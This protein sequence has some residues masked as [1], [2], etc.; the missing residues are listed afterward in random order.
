M[1]RSHHELEDE[2]EGHEASLTTLHKMEQNSQ[3][4]TSVDELYPGYQTPT[5]GSRTQ[6]AA[7]KA[8]I[9]Q[10]NSKPL[11]T[12]QPPT[13]QYPADALATKKE[14][15][16]LRGQLYGESIKHLQLKS[17]L[18]Q[19]GWPLAYNKAD[20]PLEIV[21]IKQ[22]TYW[23]NRDKQALFHTFNLLR[24]YVDE[25]QL[26]IHQQQQDIDNLRG[27]TE[28][29][30][31]HID[32]QDQVSD[33]AIASGAI[34]KVPYEN[35]GK[36]VGEERP[37]KVDRRAS[38]FDEQTVEPRRRTLPTAPMLSSRLPTVTRSTSPP[39][40]I[41]TPH[42]PLKSVDKFSGA[43]KSQYEPWQEQILRIF[44]TPLCRNIPVKEQLMLVLNKVT[45]EAALY[46]LPRA[47]LNSPRPFVDLEDFFEHMNKRYRDPDRINNQRREFRNLKQGS[48]PFVEFFS[49]F[50][51]LGEN[52]GYSEEHLINELL[53][54]V[55]FELKKQFIPLSEKRDNGL[56]PLAH[57]FEVTDN[58]NRAANLYQKQR[59]DKLVR[60][61]NKWP[62]SQFTSQRKYEPA[63]PVQ[64]KV[65]QPPAR[66]ADPTKTRCYN[67]DSY[68]HFASSC[69]NP[70]KPRVQGINAIGGEDGSENYHP[71]QED[72]VRDTP[73][74]S[75]ESEND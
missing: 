55:T 23:H 9:K 58:A 29:L 39:E 53:D 42:D 60:K 67:C 18:P 28:A 69:P 56:Y 54:K 34:K 48:M 6:P 13:P 16:D 59:D 3:D 2:P 65:D 8:A 73:P 36:K 41:K 40:V 37:A 1:A 68:G 71:D 27:E 44:D 49:Q 45:G 12:P 43:D 22:F 15:G 47:K 11:G 5:L 35:H 50:S 10:Q 21:T 30:R 25:A 66:P 61:I 72:E 31:L 51:L 46:C 38:I 57:W 74:T 75:S 4:N 26:K 19:V 14:I 62:N 70:K 33:G 64:I 63:P 32:Q 52:L 7:G 17:L 24:Y 20:E